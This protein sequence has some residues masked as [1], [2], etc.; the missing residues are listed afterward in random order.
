M[1]AV[2]PSGYLHGSIGEGLAITRDN[3]ETISR[4]RNS[5]NKISRFLYRTLSVKA[6]SVWYVEEDPEETHSNIILCQQFQQ[7]LLIVFAITIL[8]IGNNDKVRRE[9][10]T[11]FCAASTSPALY[12]A[13]TNAV[14]PPC[15]KKLSSS[16]LR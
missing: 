8:A 9:F 16:L 7:L 12:M 6:Y 4:A 1:L 14:C 13:S 15:T 2:Y 3:R 10:P 5:V 11:T